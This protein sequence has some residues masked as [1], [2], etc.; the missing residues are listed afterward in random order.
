[1]SIHPLSTTVSLFFLVSIK[2]YFTVLLN[3][4]VVNSLHDKPQ[5]CHITV[6]KKQYVCIYVYSSSVELRQ[7][8]HPPWNHFVNPC[9][10]VILPQLCAF[11]PFAVFR[12]WVAASPP[13]VCQHGQRSN[14]LCTS[15]WF[16]QATASK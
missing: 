2:Y 15:V 9:V 11:V 5:H 6:C 12:D 13:E 10:V 1:M 7:W 4:I 14:T 3:F 8:L 16:T